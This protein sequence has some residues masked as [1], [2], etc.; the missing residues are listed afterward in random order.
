MESRVEQ[1]VEELRQEES[2]LQEEL[3][4]AETRVKEIR[5]EI[6]RVQG[7]IR[8]LTGKGARGSKDGAARKRRRKASSNAAPV[9]ESRDAG[10]ESGQGESAPACA[11]EQAPAPAF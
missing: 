1:V 2:R 3:A 6:A 10:S 9:A 7:G 4:A 11:P 5:A 8:G